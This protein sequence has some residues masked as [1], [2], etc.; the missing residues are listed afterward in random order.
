MAGKSNTLENSLLEL[1][2]KG[3]TF[4]DIAENDTTSPATNL[5]VSL[6]TAYPGEAANQSTNE[7]AYGSYARVAVARSGSGWTVTANSV[8]PAANV[9]FPAASSG[10]EVAYFFGVGVG[11]SG[12]TV[13]LYFGGI[14]GPPA[15]FTGTASDNIVKCTGI[16]FSVSDRVA[17]YVAQGVS[18]PTGITEGTVYFVKTVSDSDITISTTDGGSELNITADG[19]GIAQKITPLTITS[20]PSVTPI[21]STSTTIKED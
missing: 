1:I 3:T 14:G 2:F 6:H 7:C 10:S 9:Q 19:A 20:S 17:F 8:S 16:T 11:S 13:L 21:L 4:A 18:L 5:Y 15:P 12:S